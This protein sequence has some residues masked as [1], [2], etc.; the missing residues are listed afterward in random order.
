MSPP[1]GHIQLAAPTA[2]TLPRHR[3]LAVPNAP[4]A[5][6]GPPAGAA[7]KQGPEK[8]GGPNHVI[9]G[10]V[11]GPGRGAGPRLTPPP[12][13]CL[14]TSRGAQSR[15]ESPATPNAGAPPGRGSKKTK[16]P[17]ITWFSGMWESRVGGCQKY[18]S[19]GHV[20]S[21]A[22][23]MPRQ[24]WAT[25]TRPRQDIY[26]PWKTWVI[27]R[28][29]RDQGVRRLGIP[30]WGLSDPPSRVSHPRAPTEAGPG[31]KAPPPNS[32]ITCD[33]CPSETDNWPR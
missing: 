31:S 6:P 7:A 28:K 12:R 2:A 17:R 10:Y 14:G 15:R 27:C 30:R 18:H 33:P 9:V 1:P 24:A 20:T 21:G 26:L 16:V 5:P 4:S 25:Q 29:K 13:A 22:A 32:N 3:T 23:A 11:G 8:K 19:Q